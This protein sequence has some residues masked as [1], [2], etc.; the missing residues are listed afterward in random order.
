M[1]AKK[2]LSIIMVNYNKYELTQR[3]IQS[4]REN[5]SEIRYEIIVVD[6]CSTNNSY[7]ELQRL[8]KGYNDIRI[9]MTSKNLG[10]GYGNN[11]GV[12]ISRHKNILLLN[13][14]VIVL[15]GAILKMLD[16]LLKDD[17]LGIIGCKLLN[18]D[19]SLQYSCRRFMPLGKF[20][21]ARTPIKK[22]FKK[23]IVDS[24]DS[25]YLMKDYDHKIEKE[26]DW[27]MGSCL[28]LRKSDFENVNGFSNDYFMYFEDVDLAYKLKK[29][30]KKVLYYP[31]AM[32]IHLHEQ[33]SVKKISKLS[34]IHLSS[35]IKFYKKFYQ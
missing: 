8:N 23:R 31:E 26:V 19:R 13:P 5:I 21:I 18:E 29:L 17:S 4:V 24:I 27:L 3:C 34:L 12:E 14:D 20:I 33:E 28:M 10:F 1:Q 35:M 16:R 6:N 9:I 7:S 11:K 22:I 2:E 32:M 15:E 30:G 25:E